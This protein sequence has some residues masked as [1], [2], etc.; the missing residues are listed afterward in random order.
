MSRG[1]VAVV[2]ALALTACTS[3]DPTGPGPA[4]ATAREA[5]VRVCANSASGG[6]PGPAEQA[7][8]ALGIGGFAAT[9]DTR[10]GRVVVL[11]S[12]ATTWTLDACTNTW[13][14]LP[15]RG[16]APASST[17]LLYD[18][19]TDLT[20]AFGAMHVVRTL[21]L[22]SRT[23]SEVADSSAAPGIPVRWDWAVL[24]AARR[25]VVFFEETTGDLATYGLTD[26]RWRAVPHRGESPRGAQSL[27]T[28]D[29]GSGRLLVHFQHGDTLL[30]PGQPTP[31]GTTPFTARTWSL[32]PQTW[33][34]TQLDSPTPVL[35]FG[36]LP[37]DQVLTYDAA[38][39]R[40]VALSMDEL[41]VFDPTSD[42]WSPALPGPGGRHLGHHLVDDPVT[43]RVLLLGGDVWT[44]AAG[45]RTATGVWAYDVSTNTWAQVV[46]QVNG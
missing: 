21:S 20:Y 22:A 4:G 26:H 40:A 35:R 19:E 1:V 38:G 39:H 13:E 25:R 42:E 44:P 7:R 5:P 24:D 11:D 9:T 14:R 31:S 27:A 23:W 30:A 41:F 18:A 12:T 3:G 46:P 15:T 45:W 16:T 37:P 43:G 34:W 32:D 17:T 36:Y 8:P 6:A 33:R 10:A 29:P 28:L 2:V